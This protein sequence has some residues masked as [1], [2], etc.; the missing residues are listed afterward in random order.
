MPVYGTT[1]PRLD[2]NHIHRETHNANRKDAAYYG[3]VSTRRV[4]S[5]FSLEA[6]FP[7]PFS[8]NR[9]RESRVF[10]SSAAFEAPSNRETLASTI[11]CLSLSLFLPYPAPPFPPPFISTTTPP[12]LFFISS[13]TPSFIPF[14]WRDCNLTKLPPFFANTV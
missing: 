6:G 12:P 13:S 3:G 5:G 14:E 4:H 8:A 10:I 7:F 11:T 1:G 2:N 9:A